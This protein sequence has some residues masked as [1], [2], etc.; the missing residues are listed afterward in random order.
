MK[1]F[2][3]SHQNKKALSP[4]SIK[5]IFYDETDFRL[6]YFDMAISSIAR[7]RENALCE[8]CLDLDVFFGPFFPYSN[9]MLK[10][11]IFSPGAG[12]YAS[13]K[14]KFGHFWDSDSRPSFYFHRK[15]LWKSANEWFEITNEQI[16]WMYSSENKMLAF[17]FQLNSFMSHLWLM[18]W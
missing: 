3:L 7:R 17:M 14:S 6:F 18:H 13:K 12:K 15:S 10:F 11:Y 1:A 5:N 9:W 16:F 4:F 8:E 2:I